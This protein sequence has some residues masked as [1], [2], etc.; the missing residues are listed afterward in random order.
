M[1]G[2]RLTRR[3]MLKLG[4]VPVALGIGGVLAS[5]AQPGAATPTP[6]PA[7]TP[8]VQA[9]PTPAAM[10]APTPTPQSPATPTPSGPRFAGVTLNFID[11]PEGQSDAMIELQNEAQ[12]LTGA[13][14]QVEVVPEGEVFPKLQTALAAKSP[15]YDFFV[16][17]HIYLAKMAKA[18]WVMKVTDRLTPALKDDIL[19]FALQAVEYNGQFYGLPWKAEFM[20]FIY[21]KQM[22]AEAGIAGPPKTLD[23]FVDTCLKLKEKKIV[24]YPM[25]FT[26]A[27]N[28]EQVTV[29]WVMYLS[30]MGGQVFTPDGEPA[31]NEGA[32]VEAL[33]F[34][35]DLIHK[36]QIVDQAA[37][38]LRG[39]GVRRD[40]MTG[41]KAAFA[42]LWSFPLVQMNDPAKSPRAGQFDAALAP[43]GKGGPFSVAGP[44]AFGVSAFSKNPEAA[45]EFISH[46]AGPKGHKY[47]FLKEGTAPGYKSVLAD[48]EVASKLQQ[49]GGPVY[50]EQ[51]KYLAVRPPLPYYD[52]WSAKIQEGIQ[53]ALVKQ[54]TPKQV[55]DEAA[56]FTKELQKKYGK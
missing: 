54:K 53:A 36:Y 11:N 6:A 46:L 40:L 22:L 32:G 30:A 43:A 35:V 5:C 18:G 4:G 56:A 39:G 37:L 1:H 13:K 7:P 19:P 34:M 3:Q 2:Q 31:F 44:M 26:W 20:S 52:E 51:A 45:W 50:A 14:L 12:Q 29:D 23:E 41:G 10:A 17:D 16:I 24:D 25:A 21:N 55:L 48:P 15:T 8:A 27:A 49:I 42:L 38:T 47:M 9:S 28:Y 33:Q